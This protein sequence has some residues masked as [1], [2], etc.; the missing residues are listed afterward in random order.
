MNFKEF[1]PIRYSSQPLSIRK[2]TAEPEFFTMRSRIK[3]NRKAAKKLL[4]KIEKAQNM[5][6]IRKTMTRWGHRKSI[7]ILSKKQQ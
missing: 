3:K 5:V 4:L 2:E 1:D 7:S 6:D